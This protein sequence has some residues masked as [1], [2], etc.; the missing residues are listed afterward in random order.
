MCRYYADTTVLASHYVTMKKYLAYLYHLARTDANP[1][2]PFIINAFGG[3]WD[4]L[5]EWCAPGQSDGPNH[6][7]V[8][9]A[10]FYMDALTLSKI[11][12]VLG[13]KADAGRYTA[14][15]DTIKQAFI[16]KF[17]NPETNFFGTDSLYQTYQ[18]LA[19]SL[20]LVPKA[21]REQAIQDL[22]DDIMITHNGHLNTGIIGTKYLWPVLARAGRNDVAYTI[23]T[24]RTYPGYGYWLSKGATTLWEEWDGT[25]SHNHQMFGTV[26][27]F[28]YKYLAGI[29]SPMDG[30][31]T[32]GY[33]HIRIQPFIPVGLS[34]V[35]ASVKSVYG[36]V[37]SEWHQSPHKVV[38]H[39]EVPAN[40]NA[41]VSLPMMGWKNITVTES[42]RT[43]WEKR[44]FMPNAE[45]ISNATE[46]KDRITFSVGSG[47]YNFILTGR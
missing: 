16:G 3:Y 1:A 19:L 38:L 20:N 37:V 8:N 33:K 23:A 40:S 18:V 29:R 47:N 21:Y 12:R 42:G 15:A 13:H 10:Y 43:V 28:L 2:E 4:S 35:K 44:S 25:H 31:T 32:A 9:T 36:P 27:E 6:P 24:R 26:S 5:G 30:Q 34:F 45:G 11:A 39:V 14:L 41:S 7:V 46:E 17:F 22:A